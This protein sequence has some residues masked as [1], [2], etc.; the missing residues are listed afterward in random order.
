MKEKV[1]KEKVMK[2]KVMKLEIGNEPGNGNEKEN[3]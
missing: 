2:E 3:D 1:M